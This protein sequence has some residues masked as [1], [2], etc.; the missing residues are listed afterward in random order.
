LVSR[1]AAA[2]DTPTL[3]CVPGRIIYNAQFWRFA[4]HPIGSL[5]R[6]TDT[7]AILWIFDETL[8]IPNGV[9]DVELVLQNTVLPR[10][11]ASYSRSVPM[12]TTWGTNSFAIQRASYV[13]RRLACNVGSKYPTDNS[14]FVTQNLQSARLSGHRAVA[15]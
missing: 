4:L 8:P 2:F 1:R 13:A 9:A 12:T 7:P 15:E 5:I 11:T 6:P 3:H 14:G 10:P